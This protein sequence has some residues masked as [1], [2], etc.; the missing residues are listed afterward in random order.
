MSR[1][2]TLSKAGRVASLTVS[3]ALGALSCGS[4][5]GGDRGATPDAGP[6][7][8]C[9][10]AND[11]ADLAFL[12]AKIFTPS[13]AAFAACH[14]GAATM[15]GGLNLEAGMARAAMVGKPSRID[16][17]KELVRAGDPANSYLLI[18]TGKYPGVIAPSVGTMPSRN[19]L[20]CAGKLGAID[21][22]IAAGA[23]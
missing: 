4:D 14:R 19:P 12:Q 22:W 17:S 3:C 23:P 16:P 2:R 13:C 15:A 1:R 20:L 18:I 10:E 6:S 21:R 9:L 8:D 11:H 7:A 5:D